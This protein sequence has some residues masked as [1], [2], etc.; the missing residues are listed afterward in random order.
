MAI[1]LC[2]EPY[3]TCQWLLILFNV[4]P[5]S[6]GAYRHK[7]F[8]VVI[9]DT[10]GIP[11]EGSI[12]I[13]LHPTSAEHNQPKLCQKPSVSWA[14]LTYLAQAKIWSGNT[15]SLFLFFLFPY[16]CQPTYTNMLAAAGKS[17]AKNQFWVFY[18]GHLG[19]RDFSRNSICQISAVKKKVVF[20]IL[21]L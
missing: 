7:T 5:N 16:S 15:S 11:A 19:I 4:N 20:N 2:W 8:S 10:A 9:Q 3:T 18:E 21:A 13:V 1:S 6:A 14:A 17:L 12:L